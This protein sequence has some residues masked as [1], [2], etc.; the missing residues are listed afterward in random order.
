MQAPDV[1]N[2]FSIK[3]LENLTGIK[4]H[5]IRIWEQRYGILQP[6][7]TPTNIRYYDA[8]DLKAALKVALLNSFGYKISRIHAMSS[9][10][11]SA[12]IGKISDQDFKLRALVNSMLEC[13]LAL[14]SFGI[15]EHINNYIKRHGIEKTI[16]VLIFEFLEKIGL[17]WMT[18]R[19]I[20]AQEHIASN[21][22]YRKIA[23]AIEAL[24]PQTSD[25]EPSIMLFLPEGEIHD[26]G[27]F[28]VYYLLR[29]AGKTTLYLGS[30]SPFSEVQAVTQVKKL[31][32]LYVHLTA[33]TAEF[34]ANR[35][36]QRLTNAA[37]DCEIWVSGSILQHKKLNQIPRVHYLYSL[38]EVKEAML[39]L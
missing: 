12:L 26:I 13:A 16:E 8:A 20:P 22:I 23:V 7:R 38:Q 15:E 1:M 2:R 25:Q 4:A 19:L 11:M 36:L 21:V 29:R 5:T 9:E 24:P 3:D 6:K 27:L 18:D 34:D 37:P 28:Y 39:G 30:N 31:K 35:Y 32:N 17:M 14:D 33:T 10:E